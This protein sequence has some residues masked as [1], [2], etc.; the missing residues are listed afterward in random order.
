MLFQSGETPVH[1]AVRFCHLH[2][3]KTLLTYVSKSK[4]HMDAVMLVNQAN[5]VSHRLCILM[6]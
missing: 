6:M 1:M 3:M 5:Y 2:V 4:S